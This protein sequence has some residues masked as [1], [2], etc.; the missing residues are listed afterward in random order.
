MI[1]FLKKIVTFP[2]R[3][4][5]KSA[6]KTHLD[7][8]ANRKRIAQ[9]ILI[10]AI[11]VFTV[12]IVRFSWLI[13]TDSSNGVKLS[14]RAKANYS[15]TT[16]IYAKRGTIFDR[17]GTP[18]AI[19]S[20][21]YSIYVILD[22]TYV[23]ND[24]KKLYAAPHDFAEVA[25]LFKEK[26]G[27]DENY[28]KEQLSRKGAS[29]VEFGTQ[30]KHISFTKKEE[31]EKA[32]KEKGLVGIGFTSHLARSYTGNFASNFIGLA[33]LKD[34][35]DDTKG[36]VGQFG[37]EASLNSILSG[38]NGVETL[39]KDKNGQ[40]LQGA[41]KSV[42]P[43]KDGEDVYTTL[44]Q[45]L[46][47]YL[48]NLMDTT[49]VK[50]I[51]AQEITA[52]LVKAD[53]GEILATT[54][55][56]TFDAATQK[57]IGPKDDKKS[58]KENLSEQSNLLYQTAFEPGSTFKLFTL[59]AGIETGVFH[60][61]ERYTSKPLE[62]ADAFVKDWDVK[63]FPEGRNMT[64][65][66]G[67]SHS[68]NVGMSRLQLAMGDEVWDD[69]LSRFRF[70]VPTRMGVGG[71]SFGK[72]P[73]DNIVSQVNSAFG[74]GISV[75]AAQMLRGYT[76]FAN[77]GQMLEPH[78]I[79][80]VTNNNENTERVAHREVI[81]KPMEKTTADSVLKY[82]VNVGTDT[83][84]GTAYDFAN[85]H[86]FFQV[87][88][89]EVSVKTGT[90]EVAKQTGGYYEGDTSYLYS[91]VVM[92]PSE[93]PDYIFYMTVKLPEHWTLS[94]ISDV[95]NPLLERAYQIK[96]SIDATS[97]SNEGENLKAGKVTLKNYK[98]K[99]PG[100]SLDQLRQQILQPVVVGSG[101]VVTKQSIA[102][103]TELGA[104][105][106]V[107]LLTNGDVK[108]P[109]IYDWSK[110]DVETLAKWTGLEVTFEGDETGKVAEQ[111]IKTN[112]ALKKGQKLTVKLN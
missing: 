111:S 88:G 68:S 82:M 33:S 78:F 63:D 57:V 75:T 107:L 50:D 42:T 72:L 84:F 15:E 35:D 90:A 103:G 12:F 77:G 9:D 10:L 47:N 45:T 4:V 26:L 25:T 20:S 58:D 73:D 94:F 41:A 74:Q 109:D 7:P 85:Y 83:N 29:Q 22:K 71:E 79:S 101:T 91:A 44:D 92:V 64:Y 93:N 66:E 51:G 39:E 98:G 106:R 60:P 67:F 53:T 38:K 13:V 24:G 6:A 3:K 86:P 89:K 1:N 104:N 32:A 30:G 81:G 23:S 55:R 87:D 48:D 28:T 27:I 59:A 2:F 69:Y 95:A 80:K 31:I 112:T 110:E 46:Q 11:F 8:Q 105:K 97:E 100:N 62:V 102:A 16:T 54:Q 108:M 36:L 52:T 17:N 70:G 18:I 49:P 56:P 21:D 14:S 99:N 61:N 34:G 76:A 5:A 37:L 19:D 96:S 40:A 43:A 65:A